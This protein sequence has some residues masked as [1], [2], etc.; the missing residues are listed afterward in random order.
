MFTSPSSTGPV[1]SDTISTIYIP[2][3]HK[4]PFGPSFHSDC[5]CITDTILCEPKDRKTD[6]TWKENLHLLLTI[7]TTIDDV[8]SRNDE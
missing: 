1:V 4:L 5:E 7:L 3:L 2:T 6:R 8:G